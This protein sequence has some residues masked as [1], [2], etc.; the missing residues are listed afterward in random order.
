MRRISPSALVETQHALEE[1]KKA[2]ACSG[3]EDRTKETY[4]RHAETFVRWLD[5][6]FEPGEKKR[7]RHGSDS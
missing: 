5:D 3:L 1:Y 4:I 7:L 2:V 6:R